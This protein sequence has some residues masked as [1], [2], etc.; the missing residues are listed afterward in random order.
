MP[1]AARAAP[2]LEFIIVTWI[3]NVFG[4]RESE[5]LTAGFD[6]IRENIAP[7]LMLLVIAQLQRC[8]I[9]TDG[10]VESPTTG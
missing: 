5:K 2:D 9:S 1:F 10:C 7:K 3:R 8:I 4:L 6:A